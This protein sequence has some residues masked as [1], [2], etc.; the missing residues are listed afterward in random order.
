MTKFDVIVIGAGHNGLVAAAYLARAGLKVVVLE[1]RNV[2]GGACVTEELLSGYRVSTASYVCSL[3]D[4]RIIDDLELRRFG[5]NIY[6]KDPASFTP[7]PDGRSLLFWQDEKKTLQEIAKFSEE[8][9]RRYPSYEGIINRLAVFAESQFRETPAN[10]YPLTLEDWKRCFALGGGL[11]RL[12]WGDLTCLAK[13]LR[14]SV[15]SFLDDY[16]QSDVLKSTLATDGVIGFN[17]GPSAPG[18]AYVLLH[19]MMGEVGGKRGL[20]GFVRGGMGGIT[21][22]LK[23]SAES[24][25]VVIRKDAQVARINVHSEKAGGVVLSNGEELAAETIIS[26]ADPKHTFLTLVDQGDLPTSFRSRIEGFK[27]EGHVMKVNLILGELPNFVAFPGSEAGPQHKGTIHICPSLAYMED[28]WRDAQQGIPSNRPMLECCI[29]T[30]YDDSLAPPGNHIMSIFVQY[31]PYRLKS[32]S[33]D[34]L[35]ESYGDRVVET[36]AEYAPNIKKAI[37]H[38][39]VLTPLDLERQFGLTHGNIFHGDMILS[40][41]FSLRP[42]RGWAQYRTPI[43][44]LYLCGSGT[45]PGGGV[46]GLPGYNAA[47]EILLDLK[48][49]KQ[50]KN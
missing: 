5:Y 31:A 38:R 46:T 49:R 1:R 13:V 39:Q 4:S 32:G 17:G 48:A 14:S 7:L 15:Q 50:S 42:L 11:L 12:G 36:L 30:T 43:Q 10:L 37:I 29:P 25:G 22:A 6:P 34:E 21:E 23:Q 8:D 16:F 20:W 24:H 45:H 44:N 27:M 41:L 19:H 9:A 40:Q 2:V 3:L 26:N 47:R 18:S 33:W 28:A 35:R